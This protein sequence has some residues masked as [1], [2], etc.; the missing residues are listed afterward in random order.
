[1]SSSPEITCLSAL[2][3]ATQD[4]DRAV[5]FYTTLG[6]PLVKH[7]QGFATFRVGAQY[8]NI[9]AERS[10]YKPHWWGR[11][12]FYVADVDAMH[13]HIIKSGIVPEFQPRDAPWGERYF[14]VKDPDGHELS[15]AHPL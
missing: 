7:D 14:H 10:D 3:L 1:M 9:T 6:F 4:L 2:T 8:L 15:F 12:I 13:A 5:R 11:G